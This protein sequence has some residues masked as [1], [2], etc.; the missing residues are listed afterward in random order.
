MP[1]EIIPFVLGP[2]QNNTYLVAD[3]ATRKAVVID[4]AIGSDRIPEKAKQRNWQIE[5]IWL[6][7]AH[8]DHFAGAAGVSAAFN[9]PL[10]V[11][12]HPED[13]DLYR[14]QGGAAAFGFRI[15]PGPQPTLSFEH[16]QILE[17]GES[18]VEVRHV[19]GHTP[20]SVVLYAAEREVVFCG[21]AVF[22]GGIGR[23]DLPGGDFDT[24]IQAIRTQILT[25]PP[26]TRL[27]PG[28]G[29]ETTVANELGAST[30]SWG[31]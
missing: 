26:R 2:L 10:P 17:L 14:N 12:L 31:Q 7:H 25:L 3:Q 23:T 22:R 27:L 15:A 19:P 9:P 4:P 29:P 6:T 28:H 16:G 8:F 21:D 11:A 1:L 30:L 24:L 20:G 5:Q 18:R 13:L